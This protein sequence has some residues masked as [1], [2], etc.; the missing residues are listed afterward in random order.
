MSLSK[1][2]KTGLNILACSIATAIAAPAMSMSLVRNDDWSIRWDNTLKYQ[3]VTRTESPDHDVAGAAAPSVADGSLNFRRGELVSNRVDWRTELDVIFQEKMGFRI[4]AAAWYD[5]VYNGKTDYA[6]QAS[7]HNPLVT[8]NNLGMAGNPYGLQYSGTHEV[9]E[10]H[11]ETKDWYTGNGELQD[12]F[13]FYNFDIGDMA[14]VVRA[15]R[16][17]IFYGNALFGYGVQH[18]TAGYMT[19]VDGDK[20]LSSP[21]TEAKELFMPS[22][23]ISLDMSLTENLSLSAYYG[24]E[25]LH[26]RMPSRGSFFSP[27]ADLNQNNDTGQSTFAAL[28]TNL[29]AAIVGVDFDEPDDEGSE[30]GFS[31]QYYHTGLDLEMA[32]H[33]LNSYSRGVGRLKTDYSCGNYNPALGAAACSFKYQ[34]LLTPVNITHVTAAPDIVGGSSNG[35]FTV[36]GEGTWVSKEDIEVFG[37]S[38]A[39][40]WADISWGV[41][42]TYLNDTLLRNTLGHVGVGGTALYGATTNFGPAVPGQ[43][44]L[45]NENDPNGGLDTLSSTNPQSATGDVLSVVVNA[46]GLLNTNKIWDG[47]N[48]IVEYTASQI[49]SI[50]DRPDTLNGGDFGNGDDAD[51][52]INQV[53]HHIITRFTPTW[54]SVFDGV[55]LNV[56]ITVSH[57]FGGQASGLAN[58]VDFTVYTIGVDFNVRQKYNVGLKYT[59][60]GGSQSGIGHNLKDRDNIA[61]TMKAS[62]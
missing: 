60:F 51:V 1:F 20:A 17:T 24:L 32:F 41:D 11:S 7:H 29:R 53:S 44:S 16:H 27:T 25:Y 47:G 13:V 2:K 49:M 55:D 8:N 42:V 9:D 28:G 34:N 57:G 30:Y 26:Q 14:G 19:T 46:V 45:V 18:S 22:N 31:L 62:F 12:A 21:G 10:F 36:L 40:E 33:Y 38:F 61:F 23:K 35:Y 43:L 52:N 59:N 58:M 50:E 54:Y 5:D 48:W 37:L 4:S 15:G 56:P 39:K 6:E 3:A